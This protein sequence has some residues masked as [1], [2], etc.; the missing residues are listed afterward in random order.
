[1]KINKAILC[2]DKFQFRLLIKMVN[3]VQTRYYFKA[4]SLRINDQMKMMKK[5]MEN[6]TTKMSTE[7]MLMKTIK[8]GEMIMSMV[9]KKMKEVLQNKLKLIIFCLQIKIIATDIELKSLK[10]ATNIL[11]L[12]QELYLQLL[13]PQFNCLY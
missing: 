11:D 8:M 1:M 3:Q 9:L 4:R 6:M 2:K 13:L 5:V 7:R 10:L 12:N